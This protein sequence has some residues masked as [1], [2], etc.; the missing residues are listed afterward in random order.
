MTNNSG[1]L[2]VGITN[3]IEKRIFQHKNKFRKGFTEKYN[4]SKLLYF[5]TYDDPT[6]AINREKQIKRWNRA[7]K[8]NLIN[9][10]NPTWEELKFW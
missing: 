6:L 4:I 7:K 10:K 9:K 8:I 5:E 2:Y 1:T 3:N